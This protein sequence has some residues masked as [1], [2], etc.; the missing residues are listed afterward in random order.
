M[1]T[2]ADG[3][4]TSLLAPNLSAWWRDGPTSSLSSAGHMLLG[5]A[6]LAYS[7]TMPPLSLHQRPFSARVADLFATYVA[8]GESVLLADLRPNCSNRGVSCLPWEQGGMRFPDV[9]ATVASLQASVVSRLFRPRPAAWKILFLQWLGRSPLWLRAH[10]AVPARDVDGW[11][12]GARALFCSGS[13]LLSAAQGEVPARVLSYISSFRDLL[14]HRARLA[15]SF[16]E[17]MAEPL[18]LM[19]QSRMGVGSRSVARPGFR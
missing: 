9:Y 19:G 15:S 17:V 2:D 10:P 5:S 1:L 4:C 7:H 13:P 12:L 16:E 11:G 8:L 14:P 6:W 18:F 3:R